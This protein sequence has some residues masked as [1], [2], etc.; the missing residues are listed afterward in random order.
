MWSKIKYL[1]ILIKK[2]SIIY[3]SPTRQGSFMMR[4]SFLLIALLFASNLWAQSNVEAWSLAKCLQYARQNN[5]QLQQLALQTQSAVVNERQSRQDRLPNA[6]AGL[7]SGTNLGRSIDPT[8]NTFS[9]Q[10]IG[11]IQANLSSSVTLYNGGLLKNTIAQ[12]GMEL[13]LAQLQTDE[14]ANNLTLSIIAAYLQILLGESQVSVI[15]QQIAMTQTQRERVTKLIEAGVLPAGDILDIDAQIASDNLSRVN[16]TN[17]VAAALLNL[18]Q[19]LAYYEQPFGI[20]HPDYPEPNEADLYSRNPE[21][22]YQKAL[23]TQPGLKTSMLQTQIARQQLKIAACNKLPVVSL[24]I[25]VSSNYSSLMQ[26]LASELPTGLAQAPLITASGE[27]IFS[28]TFSFEKTPLFT[29]IADN[30]GALVGVN[31][32]IPI[33]NRNRVNNS[34]SLAEIGIQNSQ[35]NEKIV[36]ERLRQNIEQAY[37]DARAALSRYQ[38]TKAN[39]DAL[40]K[41]LQHTEK[42]YNLGMLNS[43]DYVNARNRLA[44]AELNLQSAKYDYF[45]RLKII[46][47]YEG[48]PMM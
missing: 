35:L 16:G 10:A 29:Q 3:S 22:T 40:Q 47:Y 21:N 32:S 2:F 17:S 48:K 33:F 26:R 7:S 39:I 45:F 11:A 18:R 12:R 23:T 14:T 8:T 20:E 41:A 24:N 46:D 1:F 4:F 28:P 44:S 6:N 9:T 42:R 34:L 19:L 15:D 38:S 43:L 27:S 5:R 30:L 31:V 13:E 37:L 36:Q 25:N